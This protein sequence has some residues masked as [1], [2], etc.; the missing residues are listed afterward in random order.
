[1]DR[2]V[3]GRDQ[4]FEGH[5]LLNAVKRFLPQRLGSGVVH[6]TR[7]TTGCEG[8]HSQGG[9]GEDEIEALPRAPRKQAIC[10]GV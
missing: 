1:V 4:L 8:Y 3:D 10:A 5:A 2:T 7:F 6:V 9:N